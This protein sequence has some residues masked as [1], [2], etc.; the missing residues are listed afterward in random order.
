MVKIIGISGIGGAGKSVLTNA[1]GEALDATMLFWDNFYEIS[2]DPKNYIEWYS[3]TRNYSEWKYDA[4]VEVLKQ[5][6]SGKKVICPATKKELIPTDYIVFDAPLGRKHTAT[7][8][9][10]DCLIFLNT[11]LDVALARRILRDFRDKSNLNIA[12][13]FEELDFYLTASR[14]LYTMDYE[15]K[16]KFDYVV[17]GDQSV[18]ELVAAIVQKIQTDGR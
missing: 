13:I 8:Q 2:Q 3:T 5:L 4:L 17:D 14:P 12:E 7:G 6:K 16:E 18:D 9:Y 10:I 1:L 15:G 11:P